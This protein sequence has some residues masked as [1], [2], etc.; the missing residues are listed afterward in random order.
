[1]GSISNNWRKIYA[2]EYSGRFIGNADTATYAA[3]AGIATYATSAGIATYA[4]SAGI[5]TYAI[6]AGISTNIKGGAIG[7]IPYQSSPNNTTFLTN[8][9]SGTILKS[10]GVGSAPSWVDVTTGFTVAIADYATNAGISTN[11]KGGAIGNIPYQ[12]GANSTTF[13]TNGASGT[14]LKS[15]GVGFA[16]SWVDV[17]TG[18]TVA[19]ADTIKTISNAT[20]AT[21]YPTFVDSNNV[22]AD[23]ESLY[24][25]SAISY[26]P[27]TDLL[28]VSKI[29]PATIQDSGG[30]TGTANYV[31]T[32]NGSGGWSWA[33]VTGGGSPAIG[34]ITVQEEGVTVGTSLGT[35]ILN[36][37]GAAVTATSPTT[38]TAN[39]T[40]TAASNVT[41]TQTGY[42]CAN[43]ITVSSGAISIAST[44]N[45]Y[46]RKFVSTTEPTGVCDGDIWYDT[47]GTD[48]GAFS[49][50]TTL[51][52]Y[53]AA[54]PTGWT[55]S[56]THDNKA[57]RVVSGTGGGSGGT[58]NF[59]SVF[60]SRGVPLPQHAHSVNDP[61]HAHGVSDPGHNHLFPGDDQLV[62][63]NGVAGW[64][65]RV[66]A[67]FQYDA[68]STNET[69][70][71]NMYLTSDSGTGIGINGN[72]TGITIANNGTAG[73][74]MDFAVQYIDV[75]I[76]SKN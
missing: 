47:S 31:L 3:S 70:A 51:L 62:F 42:G 20:N 33:S 1:M 12:S 50:G 8:G 29:K 39:I 48:A 64:P 7:N 41:V 35:Q 27:S 23:Y 28:T 73:A 46:G 4:T 59:T 14:I 52:F 67:E 32:A 10:N 57:I 63:A 15:N 71:S 40:V 58:T 44:S 49:S 61:G 17:N 68:V 25:D 55:K 5:A 26:N 21:F 56:T 54:A 11:I 19:Q 69:N 43:P 13:L 37:I 76:C 24:T 2:I 18:F 34:G 45:A 72:G 30:G 9:A 53:Q 6:N 65:A 75:I 22:S 36:F 74:S 60:T 38:G 16:P 66:V